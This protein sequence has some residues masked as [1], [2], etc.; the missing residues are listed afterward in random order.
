MKGFGAGIAG[1]AKR[2]LESKSFGEHAGVVVTSSKSFAFNMSGLKVMVMI[3]KRIAN[4]TGI[5]HK[6][7]VKRDCGVNLG[8]DGCERSGGSNCRGL[9]LRAGDRCAPFMPREWY[10]GFR[11]SRWWRRDVDIASPGAGTWEPA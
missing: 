10:D 11:K 2:C 4:G 1:V 8:K 5:G 3:D 7:A 9:S 6:A